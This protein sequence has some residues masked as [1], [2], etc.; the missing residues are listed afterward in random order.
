MIPGR[1]VSSAPIFCFS[2]E[3]SPGSRVGVMGDSRA[4]TWLVFFLS[5]YCRN[6]GIVFFLMF[7]KMKMP[8]VKSGA[9]MKIKM[10]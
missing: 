8:K 10:M 9:N 1:N 4:P 7:Y 5:I 6:S 3:E 2:N